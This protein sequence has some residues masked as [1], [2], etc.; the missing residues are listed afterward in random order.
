MRNFIVIL[1]LFSLFDTFAQSFNNT[2]L[3]DYHG[4]VAKL[5]GDS[6]SFYTIKKRI[7]KLKLNNISYAGGVD[8]LRK[9]IYTNLKYEHEENIRTLVFILFDKKINI[10]EI[11]FCELTPDYFHVNEGHRTY[12]NDYIRSIKKT[13][14][15][16]SSK[17]L[18]YQVAMFSLHIH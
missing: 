13:K 10:I 3:K 16:W 12:Y 4:I 18:G 11:R 17:G 5:D 1:F 7:Y 2:M 8:S 15:K 6:V 9:D 14:K